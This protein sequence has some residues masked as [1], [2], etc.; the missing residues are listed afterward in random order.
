[1][2]NMAIQ[3]LICPRCSAP[4]S[5]EENDSELY[6]CTYCATQFRLAEAEPVSDKPKSQIA[7][8]AFH[9][10]CPEEFSVD[11]SEEGLNIKWVQQINDILRNLLLLAT[12]LFTLIA[13]MAVMNRQNPGIFI[14]PIILGSMTWW[15]YKTMENQ[16]AGL[17]ILEIYNGIL[18]FRSPI[19]GETTRINLSKIKQLY[20]TYSFDNKYELRVLLQDNSSRLLS[21]NIPRKD[22]ASFL[23]Y[24]IEAHLG[25]PNERVKDEVGYGLQAK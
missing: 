19:P 17:R 14:I 10:P 23:E 9:I 2:Q 8:P 3:Q 22:L 6:K 13:L 5:S 16:Y 11:E 7:K 18:E 21:C 12:I 24:R 4:V 25:I 1:M 15:R 20:C